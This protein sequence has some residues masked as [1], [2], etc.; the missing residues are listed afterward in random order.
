MR[1]YV[2]VWLNKAH[3]MSNIIN[4]HQGA[5][6]SKKRRLNNKRLIVGVVLLI[7]VVLGYF[8][9][10]YTQSYYAARQAETAS[11]EQADRDVAQKKIEGAYIDVGDNKDLKLNYIAKLNN[12]DPKAAASVYEQ[13][14]AK[15]PTDEEKAGLYQEYYSVA[16][17]SKQY[18]HAIAGALGYNN[19]RPGLE[20]YDRI[21]RIYN[22]TG[23]KTNEA[24]YLN[25]MKSL[26]DSSKPENTAILADIDQRLTATGI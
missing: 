8:A 15:A 21:A 13:A 10:K 14:I 23:D 19:L 22:T 3:K 26:L 5:P 6:V 18:S 7:V 4:T 25:K 9:Y 12:N 2:D 17:Y 16:V 20:W 24:V 11:Q 1:A